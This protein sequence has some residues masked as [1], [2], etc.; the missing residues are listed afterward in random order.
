[1][2]NAQS[3]VAPAIAVEN[4]VVRI[5]GDE[6]GFDVVRDVSLVVQPGETVCIVGESGS[7]KTLTALALMG[8]HTA[9]VNVTR[10][11]VTIGDVDVTGLSE[12]KLAGLRGDQV[13]MVFQDP[14]TSLNPVLTIGEQIREVIAAHRKGLGR[15]ELDDMAEDILKRV[16]IPAPRQRLSAYPHQLSGGMRQRILIAMAVANGPRLIIADEP[17]TALDVTIQAQVMDVM[18]A[19]VAESGAALLLIT[20]DIGLVA[21]TADRVLVMYAG[22]I[23]EEGSVFD[24]LGQPRHPY[25]RALMAS[26]PRP[27]MSPA[28]DLVALGGEPPRLNNLPPGCSFRPRC[29]HSGGRPQCVESEPRLR[30]I[31]GS[32]RSACHF[33]EELVSRIFEEGRV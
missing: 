7:G 8:L 30:P 20:H 23:V 31:S 2:Q 24:V 26:V 25:T 10:G 12:R 1:M 17:T 16:G 29:T 28:E 21:E 15:R 18:R 22:Q 5:G 14:M 4:M 9:P 6:T 11:R 3:A 13:A 19:S 32:Q 27:S 33:A